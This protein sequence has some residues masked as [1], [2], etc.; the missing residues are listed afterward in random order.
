MIHPDKEANT[1]APN[2]YREAGDQEKEISS[3]SWMK[4]KQIHLG[5]PKSETPKIPKKIGSHS[6]ALA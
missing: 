1:L 5:G 6:N 3:K 4:Q 2:G